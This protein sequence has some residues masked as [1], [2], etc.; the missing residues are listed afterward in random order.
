MSE[1]ETGYKPPEPAPV[2][3]R[4]ELPSP[5]PVIPQQRQEGLL[6]LPENQE[7]LL[8]EN[9]AGLQAMLLLDRT[10]PSKGFDDTDKDELIKIAHFRK[11]NTEKVSKAARLERK[12]YWDENYGGK[13]HEEREVIWRESANRYFMKTEWTD[14]QKEFLKNIGITDLDKGGDQLHEVFRK[15]GKGDIG[16]FADK[17]VRNNSSEQIEKNKELIAELAKMYGSE[18]SKIALLVTDGLRNLKENRDEFI[19]EARTQINQGENMEDYD[20]LKQVEEGNKGWDTTV[21]EERKQHKEEKKA[22]KREEK[23]KTFSSRIKRLFA[24]TQQIKEAEEKEAEEAKKITSL[25]AALAKAKQEAPDHVELTRIIKREDEGL[26]IA[27]TDKP[28]LSKGEIEL[29]TLDIKDESGRQLTQGEILLKMLY[30]FKDDPNVTGPLKDNPE[31]TIRDWISHE[32]AHFLAAQNTYD[33]ATYV[34]QLSKDDDNYHV[35]IHVPLDRNLKD[36]NISKDERAKRDTA[37]L[38]APGLGLDEND[39]AGMSRH[40]MTKFGLYQ[41]NLDNPAGGEAIDAVKQARAYLA[42]AKNAEEIDQWVQENK[43]RFNNDESWTKR[44]LCLEQALLYKAQGEQ[45]K[46]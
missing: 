14:Q 1:I 46:Q 45:S 18:S 10:D 16:F 24:T 5:A 41:Y 35:H 6:Q 11:P 15:K 33:N 28:I 39:L 38:L 37:I 7:Q 34:V 31:Q 3:Q 25:E 23:A 44:Q 43:A 30:Q 40:D 13:K 20:L 22:K 29:A 4:E 2:T 9:R 19:E 17:I 12:K 8:N 36:P 27:D 42:D 26:E 21:R 32:G